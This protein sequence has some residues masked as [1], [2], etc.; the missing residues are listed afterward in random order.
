MKIP[1]YKWSGLYWGFIYNNRIFD[2]HAVYMGWI[3]DS[4][5]A[6][7]KDGEFLGEIINENYILRRANGIKPINR[8]PKIPPINPI[9]PIPKIN[10]IGRINKIGWID[11]IESY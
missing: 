6:W 11:A 9:P 3:D 1:I 5:R 8:I 10:R 7:K 4:L 2:K